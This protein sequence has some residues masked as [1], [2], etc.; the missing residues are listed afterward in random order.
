MECKLA[1]KDLPALLKCRGILGKLRMKSKGGASRKHRKKGRRRARKKKKKSELRKWMD[2]NLKNMTPEGFRFI[3]TFAIRGRTRQ[4]T[5]G[6]FLGMEDEEGRRVVLDV[7]MSLCAPSCPKVTKEAVAKRA[8]LTLKRFGEGASNYEVKREKYSDVEAVR[9]W[10]HAFKKRPDSKFMPVLY[11]HKATVSWS[12]G[13]T[14]LEV[15]ARFSTTQTKKV[16]NADYITS[17]VS[18]KKL[19]VLTKETFEKVFKQLPKKWK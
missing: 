5:V 4:Q 2:E 8:S 11:R 13:E 17:Y 14:L 16:K 12:N 1:A 19:T 9:E 3:N 15:S 10:L 6:H 7:M 18:R